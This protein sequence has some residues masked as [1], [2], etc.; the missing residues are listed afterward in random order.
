[1]QKVIRQVGFA[2]VLAALGFTAAFAQPSGGE[3][4]ERRGPPPEFTQACEGKAEGDTVTLTMKRHDGET[5]EI[6]ATCQLHE[7]VL[8]ARPER[9]ARPDG[10]PPQKS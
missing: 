5:H 9:P 6:Q 1:M 4:G 7:G 10:P 3:R 2:S 8:S